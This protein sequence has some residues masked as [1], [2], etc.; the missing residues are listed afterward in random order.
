MSI[1]GFIE[2]LTLKQGEAIM[3]EPLHPSG[4]KISRIS[5]GM[6]R[7]KEWEKSQADLHKFVEECISL[8]VTT[9]D[10]ADI[11]G[12]YGCER[13][14][15]KLFEENHS[16]REK[17]ELVTKCGICLKSENKPGHRVTH[18]N[19]T[20]D[21]IITSVNQSLVNL[22]TDYID[23]LLIHRPS[24]VMNADDTA[25][26]LRKVVE[27]GKVRNV[28]VSN[29]RPDQFSLLQ[30]RLDI[31]LVT[32]QVE[33]SVL[34]TDPVYDGTFEQLQ[35]LRTN[36]MIWSPFGGGNLFTGSG[37]RVR[38]IQKV[39]QKLSEKYDSE[40]D[41]LALAWVLKHPVRPFPVLGTGKPERIRK[42]V[43]ANQLELDLQDWFLILEASNGE[44]VP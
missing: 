21:H 26:G 42:A 32:N 3:K 1:C 8:G 4:L 16:L 41:I 44:P 2:K 28:G 14:F 15:G 29:F 40:I 27:S 19:L 31:P 13:I 30:S 7:L 12:D 22:N 25:A 37:S 24:P 38:R 34:H 35:N 9:F 20:A 18:Y 11:Y 10:H 6:W 17:M 39:L 36:P 33:F 43:K 23:L 5:A